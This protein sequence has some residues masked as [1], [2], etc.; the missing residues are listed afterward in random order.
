[1]R[2]QTLIP[3]TAITLSLTACAWVKPTPQGEKVQVMTTAEVANCIEMG[4]TTI[5]LKDQVAGIARSP[6]KVKWELITMARNSAPN[7]DGDTIAPISDISDGTQTFGV[8]KCI[9]TQG[10]DYHF[11]PLVEPN[12]GA[13]SQGK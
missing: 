4:Q 12:N 13:P 5:S 6:N 10:K 2:I 11:P 9:G 3:L 1:M 8:Y 7:M